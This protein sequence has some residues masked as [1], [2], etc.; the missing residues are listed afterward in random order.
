VFLGGDPNIY[1]GLFGK[2]KLPPRPR[3]INLDPCS[4]HELTFQSEYGTYLTARADRSTVSLEE[5]LPAGSNGPQCWTVVR[6]LPKRDWTVFD[7]DFLK[8]I[9][10]TFVAAREGLNSSSIHS[11]DVHQ[12]V[13]LVGR[14][15]LL[16]TVRQLKI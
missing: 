7:R 2:S 11:H 1:M 6:Y 13:G 8:S 5:K 16:G 14:V 12:R 10:G 15:G 4:G 3:F 9:Y